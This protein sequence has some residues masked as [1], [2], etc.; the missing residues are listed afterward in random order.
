MAKEVGNGQVAIFAVF[1]G[2]RK[3]IL[4]A[5]D[6]STTDAGKRF[7][8]GFTSAATSAGTSAG[9]GF[10]KSFSL[11]TTDLG[12]DSMK[13]LQKTVAQASAA[14]SA[15]RLREQDAL[16]RVNVA[17]ATYNAS[18]AKYAA[19]TP[20]YV[21]ASESLASAQRRAS[22]AGEAAKSTWSSLST[23]QSNLKTATESAAS[24]VSKSSGSF[25]N[26]FSRMGS[27][28]SEGIGGGM[29]AAVGAVKVGIG[30]IV[31]VAAAGAVTVGATVGA[32][33][34]AGFSRLSTIE[35]AQA[36]LKALGNTS[37]DISE[38]M[39]NANTAVL[40][41]QYS[42]ADAVTGAA[43]AVA[44]GIKPGKDLTKYLKL[45]ANAAAVAGVGFSDLGL[46]M[47]Q[48]QSQNKAYTQD[49]NQ[50]ASR[51]I[52]I[53]Q[54]LQKVYGTTR[55]GLRDMLQAGEVDAEHF[56]AALEL[57]VGNASDEIGK[58]TIGSFENMKA[59]FSRFGAE[60]I[61]PVYGGFKDVFVGVTS[62]L[63]R[64]KTLITPLVDK[65][66]P[67]LAE[68]FKP[69][70]DKIG[71][72]ISDFFDDIQAAAD[73]PEGQK[74]FAD[75]GENMSEIAQALGD[76]LPTLVEFTKQS[77]KLNAALLKLGTDVAP[78]WI[79][80]AQQ[81]GDFSAQVASNLSTAAEKVDEGTFWETVGA[82]FA[83]GSD[84]IRTFFESG[85][86][87]GDLIASI[88]RNFDTV[89]KSVETGSFWETVGSKFDNGKL[90]IQASQRDLIASFENG[91]VQIQQGTD[92]AWTTI[93]GKFS[94]GG[95]QIQTAV[96]TAWTTITGKFDNGGQQ[97]SGFFA[98]L[99]G[100]F[101][102]G[103]QQIGSF[104]ND[105]GTNIGRVATFIGELPGKAVAELGDLGGTLFSS[106]KALIDGFRKGIEK[107]AKDAVAA[108]SNL[109][110][111]VAGFFPNS[112]A[113]HGPLSGAGW[114][115]IGRSGGAIMDQF[116]SGFPN[117]E[118]RLAASVGSNVAAS[119][120]SGGSGV[121]VTK[122]I[123][124]TNNITAH[125]DPR[126]TGWVIGRE[127]ERLMAGTT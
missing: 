96:E 33:L 35:T 5:V 67:K 42:L 10:N 40:G 77:L 1:K 97:I 68:V 28:I 84:Q 81:I 24:S 34:T 86:I 61:S 74:W 22:V 13:A 102:N 75:M 36:K 45:Q 88:N 4:A 89:G 27:S 65:Y 95:L 93:T 127:A 69:L 25:S 119:V 73:S 30:A 114:D 94:N 43:A 85:P 82:K 126:V 55:E 20:Q 51:G 108:V 56:R 53:Y 100:K 125:E 32:A 63:D 91:W 71:P 41:T 98:D 103:G 62:G 18:I 118:L 39:A 110:K 38:I 70:T 16:G 66:G 48:V 15:A 9:R 99:G 3:S 117:A 11:S 113:K 120:P 60:L 49:L 124:Q 14:N 19:G 90:Q 121:G 87:T 83:N 72:A 12:A 6:G 26:S 7:N 54:G 17:Q 123:N 58:T 107:A 106:G 57:N 23:A 52:P 112:P 101:A 37:V 109:M 64:M 79:H 111:D 92:V 116:N 2:M 21:R 47:N 115:K 76:S 105:V 59:A 29:Q 122:V 78:A 46:V 104:A 31:S 50:V 8:K 80:G 44:A